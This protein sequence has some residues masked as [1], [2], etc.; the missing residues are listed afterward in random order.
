MEPLARQRCLHHNDRQAVARCPV[1][2]QFYCRECVTE[3]DDRVL[4]AGCLK[5]QVRKKGTARVRLAWVVQT[6][7][8]VAGLFA[9]WLFFYLCGWMLSSIPSQFHDGTVWTK[10]VD[11]SGE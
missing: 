1:C 8:A 10:Y 6:G 4:C 5:K 2:R 3:H 11:R 7:Q 9:L